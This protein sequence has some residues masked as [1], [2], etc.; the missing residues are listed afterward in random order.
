MKKWRGRVGDVFAIEV[1]PRMLAFGQ[2]CST[3][4]FAFFNIKAEEPVPIDVILSAP[5]LFRV[6]MVRGGTTGR[7]WFYLG[8]RLPSGDLATFA[9]YRV[10][11]VGSNQIHFI[12]SGLPDELRVEVSN[13]D[14][15]Q[16]EPMAWW[17]CEH[18][19]ARLLDWYLDRPSPTVEALHHIHHYDSSG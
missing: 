8:N 3:K 4:D 1:A 15:R 17:L 13:E 7:P 19:E 12:K 5:L 11:P 9:T 18:I 6:P 2:I 10:Q 14:A 16:Y